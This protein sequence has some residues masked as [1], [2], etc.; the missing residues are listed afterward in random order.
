MTLLTA[1][2]LSSAFAIALF[3]TVLIAAAIA[4]TIRSLNEDST[5]YG[6]TRAF[7]SRHE[8]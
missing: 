5:V 4:W 8:V 3:K 6:E 2:L 7:N 1:I